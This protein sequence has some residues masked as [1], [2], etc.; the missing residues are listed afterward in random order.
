MGVF[1]FQFGWQNYRNKLL[2]AQL[3]NGSMAQFAV[4]IQNR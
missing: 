1:Y 2:M 4:E 3:R